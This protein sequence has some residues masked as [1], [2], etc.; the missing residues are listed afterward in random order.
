MELTNLKR[1]GKESEEKCVLCG[2]RGTLSHL[3]TG[4]AIALG[5]GRYRWRHDKVLRVLAAAL[6][7]GKGKRRGKSA[8]DEGL[9]ILATA[10]DW[11]LRVDLDRKLTFPEE[12][13]TTNLRPD[14][15]IWSAKTRQVVI[16]EL[17]VPWED[18]LEEAFERKAEKYSEL[19]QSCMRVTDWPTSPPRQPEGVLTEGA[20]P[21]RKAGRQLMMSWVNAVQPAVSISGTLGDLAETSKAD[22][23]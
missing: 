22:T 23:K 16:L 13:T 7:G 1:W 2:K 10:G 12:I 4:C 5:Q 18:R 3:L 11:D 9:G 14:I 20:K 15:V 17:T 21:L 6:E 8:L 19:K